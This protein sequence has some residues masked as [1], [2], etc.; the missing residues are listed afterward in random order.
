IGELASIGA[1]ELDAVV[2][3]G[4]VRGADDDPGGRAKG[5]GQIGDRWRRH[6]P[7]QADIDTGSDDPSLQGGFEQIAGDSRVLTYQNPLAASAARQGSAGRPAQALHEVRSDGT[8]PDPTANAIG[9]KEFSL[10]HAEP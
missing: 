5:P 4:I 9:T 8:D 1:K 10:R 7:E 6:R 2:I 3:K